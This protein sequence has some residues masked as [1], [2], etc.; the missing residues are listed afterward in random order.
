M[1]R[2]NYTYENGHLDFSNVFYASDG[3]TSA[4]MRG[5]FGT[6]SIGKDNS[7]D[8]MT[9]QFQ[10]DGILDRAFES[11]RRCIDDLECWARI[12]WQVGPG[13]LFCSCRYILAR[14]RCTCRVVGIPSSIS[15]HCQQNDKLEIKNS[16]YGPRN[17][18]IV[19]RMHVPD[20]LYNCN[21]KP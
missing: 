2:S 12:R 15:D 16:L 20:P 11:E 10:D 7:N 21:V 4:R 13:Y 9:R 14:V 5:I 3:Y 1:I 18:L 6:R 8:E 19:Y 17:V